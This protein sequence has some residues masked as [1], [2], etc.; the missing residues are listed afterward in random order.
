MRPEPRSIA[1]KKRRSTF[2]PVEQTCR[3][4][5]AS[6][7]ASRCLSCDLRDFDVEVNA[8]ICKDC[9]YCREACGLGIFGQSAEFNPSGY[10][11]AVVEQ[12]DKCI[13][14]LRCLYVCPDFA[15]TIREK[16]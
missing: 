16:P 8:L 13:G 3:R 11:P 4:A 15:I 5:E 1:M 12:S 2:E 6:A 10:K 7:E 14:C 9:G